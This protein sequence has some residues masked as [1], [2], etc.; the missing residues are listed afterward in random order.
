MASFAKKIKKMIGRAGNAV[1]IEPDNEMLE[2]LSETFQTVFVYAAEPPP[3]R[4]KN[5]IYREEIGDLTRLP[6]IGFVHI[7]ETAIKSLSSFQRIIE[8][9]QSIVLISSPEGL[10]K[11]YAKILTDIYYRKDEFTKRWQTWRIKK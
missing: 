11:K 9:Y 1:S 6:E 5:I 2:A 7:G 8:K 3:I 4:K 10:N